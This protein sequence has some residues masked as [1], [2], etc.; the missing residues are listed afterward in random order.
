[1]R[2]KCTKNE[3]KISCYELAQNGSSY[4]DWE[5]LWDVL[6]GQSKNQT[7]CF[8]L[9]ISGVVPGGLSHCVDHPK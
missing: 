8:G 6:F 1:M 5:V 7:F 9:R 3:L 2:V 4:C